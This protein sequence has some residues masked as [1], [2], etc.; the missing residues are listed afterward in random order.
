MDINAVYERYSREDLIT[1]LCKESFEIIRLK[2]L[3]TT[4][5]EELVKLGSSNDQ[6]LKCV[7]GIERNWL[8]TYCIGGYNQMRLYIQEL[9]NKLGPEHKEIRNNR[10]KYL[11]DWFNKT[12]ENL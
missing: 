2:T 3:L 4:A 10:Q 7:E 9:E 8:P 12:E 5:G 1:L 11:T 6:F